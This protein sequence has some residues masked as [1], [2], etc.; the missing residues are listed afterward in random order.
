MEKKYP[1]AGIP[2]NL[3]VVDQMVFHYLYLNANITN[4]VKAYKA[5][6]EKHVDWN[7]RLPAAAE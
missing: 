6:L 7:D 5:F 1:L 2:Q 4:A 3:P